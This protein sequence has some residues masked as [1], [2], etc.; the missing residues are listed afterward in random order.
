MAL[1]PVA[2]A[3]GR[4]LAGVKPTAAEPVKL[5]DALGRVLAVAVKAKRD[6]PPF[7][8]SA[9]DGYAVR[10]EDVAT[11]PARLGARND[12][13]LAGLGKTEKAD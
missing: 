4:I 10:G 13:S 7:E 5:A 11:A 9:M 6:Q 3:R 2:E 8:A 12:R 1:L